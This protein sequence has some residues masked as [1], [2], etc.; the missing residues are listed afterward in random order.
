M[1]YD[2]RVRLVID[3]VVEGFLGDE[4]VR[5]VSDPIPCFRGRLSAEEQ[6]KVFG[7]YRLD[8]FKLYLQGFHAGFTEIVYHDKTLKISGRIEHRGRTVIYV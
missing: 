6:L 4:L 1:R 2:E 3:E 8:S 7:E 5:R